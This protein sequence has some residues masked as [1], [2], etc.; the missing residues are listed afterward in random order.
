MH[1]ALLDNVLSAACSTGFGFFDLAL[2]DRRHDCLHGCGIGRQRDV[3]DRDH[4]L[5]KPARGNLLHLAMFEGINASSVI[6]SMVSVLANKSCTMVRTSTG[7]RASVGF[8]HDDQ[9]QL[10]RHFGQRLPMRVQ[11]P[12]RQCGQPRADLVSAKAET[13]SSRTCLRL[14][15][16]C[17]SRFFLNLRLPP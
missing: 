7:R 10:S 2:I 11:R 8:A 16:A 15:A 4:S 1:A 14:S 9:L 5:A 3:G 12:C 6:A 13:A 17:E